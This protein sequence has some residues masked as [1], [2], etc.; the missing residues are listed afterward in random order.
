MCVIPLFPFIVLLRWQLNHSYRPEFQL[1]AQPNDGHTLPKFV[2]VV[3]SHPP[4]PSGDGRLCCQGQEPPVH[5]QETAGLKL[6]A[7]EN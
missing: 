6:L 2:E 1:T 5:Y 7:E 4:T 3:L